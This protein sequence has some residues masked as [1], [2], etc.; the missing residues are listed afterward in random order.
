MRYCLLLLFGLSVTLSLY[1]ANETFPINLTSLH[2]NG[3]ANWEHEVFSGESTYTLNNRQGRTAL[4]AK[5][6]KSASGLVLRKKI[7]LL[8]TPYL[9]W[10]WLAENQLLS[11]NEKSKEG[12]DYVA[13]VYIV[14]DGGIR[15]WN[16]KSL[17][18]VWSSNQEAGEVWN[19]A[20]AGSK[21]KMVAVRG[22][23]AR[24]G[25][26]YQERRNVYQDLKSYFGDK[27]SKKDN[28]K[29]YRYIDAV[30][31]MTDTDNS[32]GDATSF[33]GDIVFS[34]E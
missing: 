21:V 23:G 8:K 6:Y 11:I 25:H 7:D 30:A 3:I 9:N 19:N 15:F 20:F 14:I 34:A 18:Y 22:V 1:A 10:A 16:T 33:Y 5:S 4:E 2:S 13:R 32:G 17:S 26:W 24:L 27:G 12:D 28:I 29:A 31:I